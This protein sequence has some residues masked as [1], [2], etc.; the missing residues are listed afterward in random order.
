MDQQSVKL[1]EDISLFEEQMEH[2]MEGV[3]VSGRHYILIVLLD[4]DSFCC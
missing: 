3:E 1:D 4:T 2:D